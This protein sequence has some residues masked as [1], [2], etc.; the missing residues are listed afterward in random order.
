[1]LRHSLFRTSGSTTRK[2]MIRPP[3]STSRVLAITLDISPGLK[4]RPASGSIPRRSTIGSLVQKTAPRSD[5]HLPPRGNRTTDL[6]LLVVGDAQVVRA[7]HAAHARIERRDGE[8]QK[9]VALDV[10]TDDL[11]GNILVADGDEGATDAAAYQVERGDD[12]QGREE[13]QEEIEL[14]LR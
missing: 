12:G 3:N 1:M 6:E 14:P 13:Q 10:D 7:E 5:A 4:K 2:K 8:R 11:G 9:F